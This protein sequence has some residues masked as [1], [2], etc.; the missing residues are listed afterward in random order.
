MYG[1]DIDIAA[2]EIAAVNLILQIL[3]KGE[4]L[5]LILNENIRVGNTLVSDAIPELQKYFNDPNSKRPFNWEKEFQD[6]LG[7]GGFDSFFFNE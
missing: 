3:R 7:A 1:L 2:A 4:K 6:I 5:P